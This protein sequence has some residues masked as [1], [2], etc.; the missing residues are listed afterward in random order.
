MVLSIHTVMSQIL[1]LNRCRMCGA[2]S[3]RPVLDRDGAG[4]MRAT[5]LYRC[6]GCSVVF[7]DPRAW[8][9][10]GADDAVAPRAPVEAPGRGVAPVPMGRQETPA[11]APRPPD[12]RTYGS[13]PGVSAG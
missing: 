7:A 4:A 9:E 3:Y 5:G 12:W 1:P 8:R 13:G 2:S 6:S 10:G 11:A